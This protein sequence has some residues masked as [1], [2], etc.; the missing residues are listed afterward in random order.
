[1]TKAKLVTNPAEGHGLT[2]RITD[3]HFSALTKGE[4]IGLIP[5]LVLLK[6]HGYGGNVTANGEHRHVSYE[7]AKLEPILEP[8]DRT[9]AM[10]KVQALY[11]ARTSTGSQ[12]PL[13]IGLAGEERR[14]F[15]IERIEDWAARNEITG[16]ELEQQWREHYG[17]G[18]GDELYGIP[19]DYGKAAVNHLLQFALEVGA[20]KLA[21]DDDDEEPRL[22]G[23]D[24][25]DTPD[26]E[27]AASDEA[28]ESDTAAGE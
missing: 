12:R 11:E 13:P 21:A 24:E 22:L 28:E 20:E 25:L 8:G 27:P 17:I 3:P 10:W 1:M 9:D 15:L 7:V 23:D 5:A 19:G 16:G 14:L 4:P 6:P 26:D 2:Q 18:T